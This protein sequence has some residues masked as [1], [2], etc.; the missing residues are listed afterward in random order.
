VQ[1][2][3]DRVTVDTGTE[4]RWVAFPIVTVY[5]SGTANISAIF[6]DNGITP[7]GNPFTGSSTGL[8]YFYAADGLYDVVYSGGTP[9]VS[10]TIGAVQLD[11]TLGLTPGG[12]GITDL[13]GLTVATQGLSVGLSGSDFNIAS[14]GSGHTFNLP[15]AGSSRT[16][17]LA[18][19]D[20]ITFSSKLASINA[21]TA[22]AQFIA[23]GTSG[24]SPAIVSSTNTH[25]INL[26]VASLTNT[27]VLSNSDWQLFNGKQNSLSGSSSLQ[28]FRGDSVFATL[29]T[30]VVPEGTNLYYTDA[31]S[32][33]ALSATAP[34]TYNNTTGVIAANVATGAQNGYLASTDWTTFNNK[35][36]SLNGLTTAA[37]TFSTD[38]ASGTDFAI[39]SAGSTHVF[40]LP[41]AGA[42]NRGVITTGPQTIAG[43]K[44]F[45]SEVYIQ[46][47]AEFT[48][49]SDLTNAAAGQGRLYLR[50]NG[51]AKHELVVI[52]PSGARQVVATEP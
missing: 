41:S 49:I 35:M 44:T 26:P 38:G 1:R 50:I 2:F 33:A 34:V 3:N 22:T 12:G 6:S 5:D 40:K 15:Q 42:A 28:Y 37:Q 16:G 51:S 8:I 48:T 45:S 39:A 31:R 32:R 13:N 7:R 17:K 47:Y 30:T 14:Y 23:L 36:G 18:S 4:V 25:T 46:K 24:T 21:L 9:T 20:W 11:D 43:P 10:Y 27:G 29:N 19:S 52:F